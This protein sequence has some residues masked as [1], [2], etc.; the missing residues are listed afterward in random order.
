MVESRWLRWLGPGL[1]GLAVATIVVSTTVGAGRP[2]SAGFGPCDGA[3]AI[4]VPGASQAPAA[5]RAW[6]DLRPELDADGALAGQQLTVGSLVAMAETTLELPPESF[7]AGPFGMTVLVGSDDGRRSQLDLL[8]LAAGCRWALD[9][10]ATIIR[11]A[12][13]DAIRGGIVEMRLDR[14]DRADAGIWFRPFDGGAGARRVLGPIEPDARFGRTWTTEFGWDLDG[15]RLAIQSCG[16]SACR[17]RILSPDDGTTELLDQPDLGLLVGLD[18][19]RMITYGACRGLPCPLIATDLVTG[20]RHVLAAD[21]GPAT[22]VGPPGHG[23]LVLERHVGSERR[24]RSILTDGSS[25]VDLGPIPWDQHL[26]VTAGSPA[27][28]G[29]PSMETVLL[30]EDEPTA[31][32]LRRPFARHITDGTPV[33]HDE[34]TR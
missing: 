19:E 13:I 33:L 28:A 16:E 32:R 1:L 10:S 7:A 22:L 15:E 12:T 26:M 30:G 21:A 20:Q 31:D 14:A 18:G 9:S 27:D 4:A 2:R 23:R 8:D 11:R 25:P 5:D 6:F 29:Q 3:P 24:L 34:V 17:T